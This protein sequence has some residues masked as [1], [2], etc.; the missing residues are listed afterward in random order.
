MVAY[1][2]VGPQNELELEGRK[3]SSMIL[4]LLSDSVYCDFQQNS[5]GEPQH[6][7]KYIPS[8]MYFCSTKYTPFGSYKLTIDFLSKV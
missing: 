4:S 3:K 8:T 2:I 1:K 6:K 5:K 7:I